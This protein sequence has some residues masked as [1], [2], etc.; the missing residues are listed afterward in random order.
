MAHYLEGYFNEATQ[1]WMPIQDLDFFREEFPIQSA[2]FPLHR[3]YS[4]ATIPDLFGESFRDMEYLE[5]NHFESGVFYR[6][7]DHF[8]FKPFPKEAQW[9][10]VVD[11]VSGDINGDGYL[12]LALAQNVSY[13]PSLN[14]PM[15]S[16]GC[17]ILLNMGNGSFRTLSAKESGVFYMDDSE[18]IR[19]V[20]LNDDGK[21]DLE[22]T[23]RDKQVY[24]FNNQ[25]QFG[26]AAQLEV[27]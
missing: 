6:R 5:V 21:L 15:K 22:A 20:D 11:L 26:G 24:I 12:D 25:I 14:A 17:L 13:L 3:L 10:P 8:E 18:R 2:R 27:E 7:K 1:Q 16:N 23:T 4:D 9:T 19:L